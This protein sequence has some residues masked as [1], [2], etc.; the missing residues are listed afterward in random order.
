MAGCV[1]RGNIGESPI[2]NSILQ[3]CAGP[4]ENAGQ[5]DSPAGAAPR[6]GKAPAP[7]ALSAPRRVRMRVDDTCQA[8]RCAGRAVGQRGSH[9]PNSPRGI[10][11]RAFRL[12][13]VSA[14]CASRLPTNPLALRD[15]RRCAGGVASP[16]P[17]SR[18]TR[19]STKSASQVFRSPATMSTLSAQRP[20]P[21]PNSRLTGDR[22]TLRLRAPQVIRATARPRRSPWRRRAIA[23][24]PSGTHRRTGFSARRNG[25]KTQPRRRGAAESGC[26]FVR[27]RRLGTSFRDE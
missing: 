2:V 14:R 6:A 24:A 26:S 7:R 11:A 5:A 16:R 23:G 12:R 13:G 27:V 17:L 4:V 25:S 15:P 21:R 3:S 18:A 1:S 20:T 19:D 10:G 8:H 22:Q 9:R